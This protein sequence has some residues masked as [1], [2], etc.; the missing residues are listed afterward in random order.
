MTAGDGIDIFV[1]NKNDYI[2]FNSA[3]E[4]FGFTVGQD[5]ID[6]SDPEARTGGDQNPPVSQVK[7][8]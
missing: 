2:P 6:L 5:K 7:T 3:D 1:F 8:N 4:I